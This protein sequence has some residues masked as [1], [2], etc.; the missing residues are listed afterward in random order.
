MQGM[1]SALRSAATRAAHSIPLL[2]AVMLWPGRIT[3]WGLFDDSWYYIQMMF[4][5]GVLSVQ[6]LIITLAVTPTT[7]V[8]NRI[9]RGQSIGRW[10][11]K[12]RKHFGLGC[13]F[14]AALHLVHYLIETRS[15]FDVLA[16]MTG[17]DLAVGWVAFVI[18]LMLA[19][20]SNAS[21]LRK[22]G[23]KWKQLHRW[24]YVAAGLSFL[25]WYLLDH[26]TQRVMFWLSLVAVI[27]LAHLCLRY[28][29]RSR[30]A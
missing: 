8:I 7:L 9:G 20:T 28:L 15:L 11:I 22:M 24:V 14:Y 21:S 3:I 26:N 17:V 6:L 25:H 18:F 27:K 10:L 16:E 2:Y 4:D 23:P 19:A 1:I 12:R 29:R 30:L 5:T 13:F